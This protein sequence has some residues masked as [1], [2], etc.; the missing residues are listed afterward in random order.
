MMK[1]SRIYGTGGQAGAPYFQCV[2]GYGFLPLAGECAGRLPIVFL[3][4]GVV[5]VQL[6]IPYLQYRT[7]GRMRGIPSCSWQGIVPDKIIPARRFPFLTLKEGVIHSPHCVTRLI[8]R[9]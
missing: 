6:Y 7:D 8:F 1:D 3:L 4:Q 5:D 2:P 9:R